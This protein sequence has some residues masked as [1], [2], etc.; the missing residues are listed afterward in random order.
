MPELSKTERARAAVGIPL[1][2][3]LATLRDG[4][5]WRTPHQSQA[6]I[7]YSAIANQWEWEV[8]HGSETGGQVGVAT[9]LHRALTDLLN[10]EARLLR[11]AF[12]RSPRH[13]YILPESRTYQSVD[14]SVLERL[15][16][17]AGPVPEATSHAAAARHDA[18]WRDEMGRAAIAT[19]ERTLLSQD[20]MDTDPF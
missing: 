2:I 16:R 14:N 5:P 20:I 4:Y 6:F 3:T 11:E 13:D 19:F 17:G 1:G 7:E 10:A 12:L 8:T 18:A 15:W 9:F